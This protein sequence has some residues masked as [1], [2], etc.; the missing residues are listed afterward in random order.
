MRRIVRIVGTLEFTVSS[1]ANDQSDSSPKTEVPGADRQEHGTGKG[2]TSLM[3]GMSWIGRVAGLIRV[4][5]PSDQRPSAS[6]EPTP[7]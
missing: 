5:A 6:R 3:R 4:L 1:A 2:L 7:D